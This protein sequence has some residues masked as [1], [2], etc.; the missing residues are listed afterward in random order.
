MHAKKIKADN[1]QHLLELS[2]GQDFRVGLLL[3]SNLNWKML[4]IDQCKLKGNKQGS[5]RKACI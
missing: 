4:N 5:S 2:Q 3:H 1:E